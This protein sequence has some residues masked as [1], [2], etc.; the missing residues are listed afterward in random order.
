MRTDAEKQAFVMECLRIE[1]QGGNV[2][3]YIAQNWPSYTPRATWYNLQKTYLGRNVN[4]LTE[5]KPKI[6][7]KEVNI[8]RKRRD[9][10]VVLDE[11]LKVIEAH[12]DPIAWFEKEGYAFPFSGWSNLKKW[13][14]TIRPDD[15]EKLPKD[16]KLYYAKH[17]IQRH[18]K[19]GDAAKPGDNTTEGDKAPETV[20]MNGK[21][22]EKMGGKIKSGGLS[23]SMLGSS[24]ENEMIV[25]SPTC[26]QPAKPSGVTVPDELPEE[27]LA[28]AALMSNVVPNYKY[29]LLKMSSVVFMVLNW[30]DKMTNQE[31]NLILTPDQWQ[32]LSKEIITALK[33]L[34]M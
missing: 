28:I 25:P 21:E 11:I 15:Y 10:N 17:G 6:E 16:M 31:H 34:G 18:G 23:L 14:Q 8:M 12:G 7:R 3:E 4:Q 22:Y 1:K 9:M 29:E 2:Q 32:R 26:C 13:A 20:V 5:G 30:Q 24:Y 27:Q 33:Q 19:A